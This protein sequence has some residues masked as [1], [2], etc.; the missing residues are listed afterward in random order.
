LNREKVGTP[1]VPAGVSV[2]AATCARTSVI[3]A[4]AAA[5]QAAV[6][7]PRKHGATSLMKAERGT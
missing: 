1:P 7:M 2:E 3:A 4:S 6:I 5:I